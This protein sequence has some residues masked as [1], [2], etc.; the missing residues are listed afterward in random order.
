[1]AIVV[2]VDQDTQAIAE[3]QEHRDILEGQAIVG[4]QALQVTPEHPVRLDIQD[5]VGLRVL[6]VIVGQ[7]TRDIR[8]DLVIQVRLDTRVIAGLQVLLVIVEYQVDQDTLEL[9]TY[10][11]ILDI[12]GLQDIVVPQEYQVRH[13]L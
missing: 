12:A 3:P 9:Q 6:L 11:V 10:P 1:V 2:I 4:N 8:A 13:L 5:I 7:V